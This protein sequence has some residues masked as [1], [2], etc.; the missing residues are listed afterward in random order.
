MMDPSNRQV[1]YR[2]LE[3]LRDKLI[4]FYFVI[5][6]SNYDYG[7]TVY[8]FPF[9]SGPLILGL[10]AALIYN[11]GLGCFTSSMFKPEEYFKG[12]K[13]FY[14]VLLEKSMQISKYF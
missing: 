5:P 11:L 13:S 1:Q 12:E 14:L 8:S 10:R 4:G 7:P 6:P 2:L 3:A 9:Q